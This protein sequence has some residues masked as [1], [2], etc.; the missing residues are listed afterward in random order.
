MPETLL[1]R[2]SNKGFLSKYCEIFK[3]T[4]FAAQLRTTASECSYLESLDIAS[5]SGKVKVYFVKFQQTF[6]KIHFLKFPNISSPETFFSK[7]I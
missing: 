1:K 2:D 3:N 7:S 5:F 4:Y 6:E